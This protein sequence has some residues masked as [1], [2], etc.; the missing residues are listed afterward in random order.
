MARTP[1]TGPSQYDIRSGATGR[2]I[3]RK[4]A[5]RALEAEIEI[6]ASKENLEDLEE[7]ISKYRIDRFDALDDIYIALRKIGK[8]LTHEVSGRMFD[9]ESGAYGDWPG[10]SRT[11][12]WWRIANEFD[13]EPILQASQSL[14]M[15]VMSGEVLDYQMDTFQDEYR[16][17]LSNQNI[18]DS[19]TAWKYYVHMSGGSFGFGGAYIPPRPFVPIDVDN[20]TEGEKYTVSEIFEN[21][22]NSIIGAKTGV[23]DVFTTAI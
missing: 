23:T 15:S 14:Y 20:L 9:E 7:R 18:S 13:E 21:E 22:I 16:V 8:V 4:E 10:L 17:E 19:I 3:S 2:F 5:A 6:K 1:F 12:I 11:A